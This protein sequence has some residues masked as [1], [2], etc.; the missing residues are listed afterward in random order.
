LA[1]AAHAGS[2]TAREDEKYWLDR[3]AG[4]VPVLDLPVDRSR[5]RRR[6]FASRREDRM[7]DP[8]EVAAIKRLGAAQGASLYATLLAAFAVLLHRVAG[9]DD[10]VIGIPTAGQAAEGL[11]TLVGHAVNVLPLRARVDDTASF[12]DVL[13][14]VRNDLLDAFEHQRSR[15]RAIRRACRWWRCCSISTRSW[16]KAR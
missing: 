5:P 10:V 8:T 14:T 16:T 11:D 15:S 2:E 13:G 12:A 7:L 4:T 3:F 9:Q 1:E 6:S